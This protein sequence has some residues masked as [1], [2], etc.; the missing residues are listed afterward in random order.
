MKSKMKACAKVKMDKKMMGM[1]KH[2]KKSKKK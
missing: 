1:K 2:E